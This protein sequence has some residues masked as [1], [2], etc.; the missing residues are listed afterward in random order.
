[1]YVYN[2]RAKNQPGS[3]LQ[4]PRVPKTKGLEKKNEKLW[5]NQSMKDSDCITYKIELKA[6]ILRVHAD[7]N[8]VQILLSIPLRLEL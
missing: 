2:K 3:T 8:T 5:V 6:V 7:I 4:E 1:M